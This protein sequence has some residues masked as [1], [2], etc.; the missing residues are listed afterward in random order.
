MKW[1]Y[2]LLV[3]AFVAGCNDEDELTPS[4]GEETFYKLPQG[5]HD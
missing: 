4:E 3:L 5:N 2:L 1:I